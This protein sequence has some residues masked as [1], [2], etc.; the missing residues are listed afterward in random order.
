MSKFLINTVLLTA[1]YVALAMREGFVVHW[2]YAFI[3]ALSA[4]VCSLVSWL[5]TGPTGA[6]MSRDDAIRHCDDAL[7]DWPTEPYP[8]AFAPEG[9]VWL[10]SNLH[11]HPILVS[12]EGVITQGDWHDGF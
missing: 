7:R 1:L 5:L 4:L 3:A 6:V 2:G 8:L 10:S 11:K 12:T 9:W